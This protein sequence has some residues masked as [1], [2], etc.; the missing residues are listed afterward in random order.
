MSPAALLL[1]ATRAR[2]RAPVAKKGSLVA[3]RVDTETRV[4][5][6]RSDALGTA[7]ATAGER[8]LACLLSWAGGHSD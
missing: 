1:G 3:F 7:D 4:R 2:I 5:Q 8:T 6:D